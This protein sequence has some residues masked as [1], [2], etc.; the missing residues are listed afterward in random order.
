MQYG[1]VRAVMIG[2]DANACRFAIAFSVRDH[3]AEPARRNVL[4][5]RLAK[6]GQPH[7]AREAPQASAAS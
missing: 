7:E 2:A 1:C 4:R 3:E 5:L 6:I